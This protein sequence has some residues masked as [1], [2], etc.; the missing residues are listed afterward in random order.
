MI[1]LGSLALFGLAICGSLASANDYDDLSDSDIQDLL[2]TIDYM[3]YS[4]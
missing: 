1:C 2:R 3:E 4:K